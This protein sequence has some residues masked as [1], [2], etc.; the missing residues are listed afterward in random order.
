MA[1]RSSGSSSQSPSRS[2]VGRHR[3]AAPRRAPASA[4]DLRGRRFTPEEHAEAL[5]LIVGG[6]GRDAV[7]SHIGCTT[8]SLRRWHEGAKA[9]GTL[10][11]AAGAPKAGRSPARET[12]AAT[13]PAATTAAA[14][15]TGRRR[16][17]P[18][19]SGSSAGGSRSRPSRACSSA[20]GLHRCIAA[21]GPSGTS[22]PGASRRRI[23]TPS[24]SSTTPS[25]ASARSAAGCS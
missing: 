18:S 15:T 2:R 17:A 23:A 4:P 21:G 20:R 11:A 24:G 9:A 8:E 25:C 16:S 3:A 12:P 7:A 14:A 10:P 19:S 1:R 13:A 22:T 6:M 5:R